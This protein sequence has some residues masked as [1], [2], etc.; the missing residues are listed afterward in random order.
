V[1]QRQPRRAAS[2]AAT[3]SRAYVQDQR[4]WQECAPAIERRG[5]ALGGPHP[6]H[7]GKIQVADTGRT[8]RRSPLQ[9]LHVLDIPDDYQFMDPELVELLGLKVDP[10]IRD[11]L[12]S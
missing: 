6:G 12:R 2:I 3:I 1:Q 8:P 7:G 4:R 9:A 5:P 11:A 10:L